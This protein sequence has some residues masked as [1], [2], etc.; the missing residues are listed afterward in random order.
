MQHF[1]QHYIPRKQTMKI[2]LNQIEMELAAL[3][4]MGRMMSNKKSGVISSSKRKLDPDVNGVGGEIAVCK[5]F[6][7]YPDLTIGPHRRGYDLKVKGQRVDVK[8]TTYNPGYLQAQIN[9]KIQDCDIYI[10]VYAEIPHFEIMGGSRSSDFI[11]PFNIKDVGYGDKYTLETS[12]LRALE[13]LF[14]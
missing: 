2:T 10:L 7:R 4:G 13:F 3:A 9:K 6:N 1:M 11:Q 8:T 14:V 5:Y 12:Q